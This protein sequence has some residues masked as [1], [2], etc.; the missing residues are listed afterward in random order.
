M[1][2]TQE[3][4]VKTIHDLFSDYEECPFQAEIAAFEPKGNEQW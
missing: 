1:D 4:D 3:Q 2:K